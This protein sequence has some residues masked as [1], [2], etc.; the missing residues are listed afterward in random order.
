MKAINFLLAFLP[1]LVIVYLSW[2]G[3]Q[4]VLLKSVEID[5]VDICVASMLTWYIAR[6]AVEIHEKLNR[7]IKK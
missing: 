2:I 5:A 3:A 6:D 1:A 7:N 4:F